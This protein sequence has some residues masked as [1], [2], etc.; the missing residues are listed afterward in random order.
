MDDIYDSIGDAAEFSHYARPMHFILDGI[1]VTRNVGG[2][3]RLV[4]NISL[5][6]NN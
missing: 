1:I 6:I 2:C 5:T 3:G 4:P